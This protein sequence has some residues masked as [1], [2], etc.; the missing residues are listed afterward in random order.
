MLQEEGSFRKLLSQMLRESLLNYPLPPTT[1]DFQVSQLLSRCC[2]AHPT[3]MKP[4]L[5]ST[6][7]RNGLLV[8]FTYNPT[9]GINSENDSPKADDPIDTIQP[10]TSHL[11][12]TF[13]NTVALLA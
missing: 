12:V 8:L 9:I 6:A 11:P 10:R 4:T 7:T 3:P 13:H 2:W 5:D 1:Q